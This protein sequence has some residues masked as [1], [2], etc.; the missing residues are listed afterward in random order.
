VAQPDGSKKVLAKKNPGGVTRVELARRLAVGLTTVDRLIAAGLQTVGL[1]GRAKLYSVRDARRLAKRLAPTANAAAAEVICADYN[2]HAEDFWSRR[3]ELIEQFIPDDVWLRQLGE[4]VKVAKRL[5]ADWPDALVQ[6]LGAAEPDEAGFDWADGPRVRTPQGVANDSDVPAPVLRPL[7]QTFAERISAHESMT[8][9]FTAIVRIPPVARMT[10]ITTKGVD[11]A[12][13]QLRAART[14]FR[15]ARV[16]IRRDHRR[17][18]AILAAID[19]ACES[20][21]FRWWESRFLFYGAAG[22]PERIRRAV[23]SVRKEAL[24][25]F[26]TLNGLLL[27]NVH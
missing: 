13:A 15:A 21:R 14:S 9:L 24:S 25:E 23:Q 5:T 19:A 12:R 7:M 11:D 8:A 26:G 6:R 22:D 3:R 18:Q 4:V 16:A 10:L 20:W 1:R 17:R 2:S 27:E